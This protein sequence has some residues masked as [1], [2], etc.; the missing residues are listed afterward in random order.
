MGSCIATRPRWG[1]WGVCVV[2]L[3]S[4]C[5]LAYLVLEASRSQ[6][7]YLSVAF[8]LLRLVYPNVE[9]FADGELRLDIPDDGVG[10]TLDHRVGVGLSSM[11][12]HAASIGETLAV[13]LV[14]GCGTRILARLP[15]QGLGVL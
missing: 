3:A 8:T 7:V 4:A 11:R 5:L 6:P 15:L 12:E 13:E 9:A 14:P 2:L 10:M 1:G